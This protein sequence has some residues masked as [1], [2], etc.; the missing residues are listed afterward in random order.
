MDSN[1]VLG[2]VKSAGRKGGLNR[3]GLLS[4]LAMLPLL[5]QLLA[6]KNAAAQVPAFLLRSAV[7]RAP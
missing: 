1:G 5:S 7:T 6:A 2:N 3:R 4:G